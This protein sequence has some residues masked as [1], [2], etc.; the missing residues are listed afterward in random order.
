MDHDVRDDTTSRFMSALQGLEKDGDTGPMAELFTEDAEVLSIDGHGPRSGP[1]GISALFT[2]YVE[3]FETLATTFTQAVEGD[4]HAALEWRTQATRPGGHEVTYTGVTVID[5]DG[6]KVRGFRTVYDSAALLAPTAGTGET[7]GS[8]DDKSY[9]GTAVD[10][11]SADSEG[12]D[13]A[14]SSDD[15]QGD[16]DDDSAGQYGADSG[17]VAEADREASKGSTP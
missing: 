11:T 15:A 10:E 3:Q 9:D 1:E 12:S 14:A 4:G 8:S 6:D 17:F 5:L 16:G 13:D 7:H 2:Q